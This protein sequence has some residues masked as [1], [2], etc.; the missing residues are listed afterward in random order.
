MWRPEAL[1]RASF[2]RVLKG[3]T[4]RLIGDSLMSHHYQYLTRCVLGCTYEEMRVNTISPA[5]DEK[6]WNIS[7]GA[8]GFS[9]DARFWALKSLRLASGKE[10]FAKGCRL[11]GGG[12]ID[13][14]RVN[15]LPQNVARPGGGTYR[16]LLAALLHTLV[17]WPG[18]KQGLPLSGDDVVMLNFGLHE[19]ADLPQKMSDLLR[20]WA[21]EGTRAPRLLWRQ[22]S[23]QHWP[24]S[25][26]GAFRDLSDVIETKSRPCLAQDVDVEK[27]QELYDANVSKLV[28]EA[29]R[30][31]RGGGGGGIA[32][33][34]GGS[35]SSGS[36]SGTS[37][38]RQRWANVLDVFTATWQR[39]DDHANLVEGSLAIKNLARTFGLNAS[40]SLPDCTHYCIPGSVLRFW[41]Q[42]LLVSLH[43]E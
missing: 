16:E 32:S 40:Y 18:Y 20:W 38:A 10:W 23:P 35:S 14:R 15:F 43:E 8:A 24:A 27:A 1:T 2:S 5:A 9:T 26:L 11:E 31:G 13:F 22:G 25:P 33:G 30:Q 36:H 17:Y 28:R 29:G 6:H 41:T 7:L 42:A 34:G 3:R 39:D 37:S 12:R 4:L 19:G 21:A